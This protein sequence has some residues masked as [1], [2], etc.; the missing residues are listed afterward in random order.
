MNYTDSAYFIIIF[1]LVITVVLIFEWVRG[2]FIYDSN[3]FS[4]NKKKVLNKEK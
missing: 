1:I 3:P 4:I 2:L